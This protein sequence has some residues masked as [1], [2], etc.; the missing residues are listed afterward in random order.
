MKYLKLV[1]TSL[2]IVEAILAVVPLIHVYVDGKYYI[3][4]T[5]N[6]WSGETRRYYEGLNGCISWSGVPK[7]VLLPTNASMINFIKR[8]MDI[9][10]SI[11]KYPNNTLGAD[12]MD[13]NPHSADLSLLR[14]SND[15]IINS[16]PK[17]DYLALIYLRVPYVS[18]AL[19]WSRLKLL[20]VIAYVNYGGYIHEVILDSPIY[21]VTKSVGNYLVSDVISEYNVK[22]EPTPLII[23]KVISWILYPLILVPTSLLTCLIIGSRRYLGIALVVLLLSTSVIYTYGLVSNDPEELMRYLMRPSPCFRV[24]SKSLMTVLG[25]HKTI[26]VNVSN[27][28]VEVVNLSKLIKPYEVKALKMLMNYLRKYELVIIAPSTGLLDVKVLGAKELSK[29]VY[30]VSIDGLSKVEV[31]IEN[32]S[33]G[34]WANVELFTDIYLGVPEVVNNYLVGSS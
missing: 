15:L 32:L 23:L 20:S 31:I 25:I 33:S 14:V 12:I 24:V 5:L 26:E 11:I 29:G 6:L 2:I 34:S 10:V 3:T 30:S 18:K 16:L 27:G 1:L 9:E 4:Y 28:G 17:G 13:I 19:I 7:E 8:L 22:V 21:S